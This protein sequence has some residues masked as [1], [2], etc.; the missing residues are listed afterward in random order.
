M[1]KIATGVSP[2]VQ[3][4]NK[5]NMMR[6]LGTAVLAGAAALAHA[7]P[8]ENPMGDV[9]ASQETACA[10]IPANVDRN[11]AEMLLGCKPLKFP[12]RKECYGDNGGLS[13]H[14]LLLLNMMGLHNYRGDSQQKG[15]A[16]RTSVGTRFQDKRKHFMQLPAV[17]K[18]AAFPAAVSGLSELLSAVNC[19]S[20]EPKSD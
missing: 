15:T 6:S 10:N 20:M 5:L 19:K 17:E 18:Q 1:M 13:D 14:D 12:P 3:F 11:A 16:Y 2:A 9:F 7:N 8:Q 4:G